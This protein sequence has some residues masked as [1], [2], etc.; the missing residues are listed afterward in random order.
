[1]SED[2]KSRGL[3]VHLGGLIIV[4]IIILIL[5]KFDIKSEIDSPKFQKNISS[6]ESIWVNNI[7]NPNKERTSYLFI[8][9]TQKELEKVQDNFNKNVFK[10]LSDEE[11]NYY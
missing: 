2:S 3:H 9:F 11:I 8:R 7:V 4:I 10:V 6:L 1:M 5:F